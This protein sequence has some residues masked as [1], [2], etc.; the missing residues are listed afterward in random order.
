MEC[1]EC[2]F[3]CLVFLFLRRPI[4]LNAWNRLEICRNVIPSGGG[5]NFLIEIFQL[6]TCSREIVESFFQVPLSEDS[7]LSDLRLALLCLRD[8]LRRRLG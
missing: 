5:V 6:I 1:A 8:G 3:S 4:G 7:V 2:C